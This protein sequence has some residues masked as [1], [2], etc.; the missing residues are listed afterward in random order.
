MISIDK[1][2]YDPP[3]INNMSYRL[4]YAYYRK[5]LA[6]QAYKRAKIKCWPT[7]IEYRWLVIWA[8]AMAHYKHV[9][10]VHLAIDT[11]TLLRKGSY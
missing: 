8:R 7:A 9:L 3:T 11:A 1:H 10:A 4:H 6:W 2:L 5:A